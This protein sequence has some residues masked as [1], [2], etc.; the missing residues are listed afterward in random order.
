MTGQLPLGPIPLG[1]LHWGQLLQ[2]QLL[3]FF[4]IKFIY[5]GGALVHSS[6]HGLSSAARHGFTINTG[7]HAVLA[8]VMP[9]ATEICNIFTGRT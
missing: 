6:F 2:G 3:F 4:F 5:T 8:A 9:V 7:L 1:Q